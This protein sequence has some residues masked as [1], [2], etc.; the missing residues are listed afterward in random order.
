MTESR[1]PCRVEDILKEGIK[2]GIFE[3]EPPFLLANIIVYLLSLEPLRGWNL[4][5]H[6]KI[7]EINKYMIDF[8]LNAIVRKQGD[9]LAGGRSSQLVTLSD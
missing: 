6:H 8:I 1:S 2:Q 3:I 4:R 9:D 5:K 7:E